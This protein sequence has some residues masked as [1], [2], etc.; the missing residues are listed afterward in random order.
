[1]DKSSCSTLSILRLS[2]A[3]AI[4]YQHQEVRT[5]TKQHHGESTLLEANAAS[6][7]KLLAECMVAAMASKAVPTILFTWIP[8]HSL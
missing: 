7:L 4:L 2:V 3:V 5:K 8:H 6:Q 1:M